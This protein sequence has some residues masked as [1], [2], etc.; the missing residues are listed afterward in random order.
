MAFYYYFAQSITF[1]K[2]KNHLR[3]IVKKEISFAV[4]G[5]K[6]KTVS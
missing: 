3:F 1:Y 2:E 5:N 4:K 6:P